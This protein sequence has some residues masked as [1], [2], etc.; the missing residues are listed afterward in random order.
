MRS[1]PNHERLRPEIDSADICQ[2]IFKSLFAGLRE[3][4][5]DLSRPEQLAKLLSAM[6]RFK[7]ATKARRLSVT[8]REVLELDVPGD[9]ADSGPGPE[10]SVEDR[11][12][13]ETIVKLFEGDELELLVRRLDDQPWSVIALAVGGTAE[14]LRNKL[15]RALE[16]VRD[17]PELRDAF[18]S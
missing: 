2:S 18:D 15:A 12:A 3:G 13:L 5:F 6:V 4:R 14:G 16:R 8:L 10:K 11:D 17:H 9:R 1:R 7:V